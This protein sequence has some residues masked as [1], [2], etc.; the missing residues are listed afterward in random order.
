MLFRV[1]AVELSL[2]LVDLPEDGKRS[3][4]VVEVDPLGL[5]Q[6]HL[7]VGRELL[8]EECAHD[9]ITDRVANDLKTGFLAAQ[10]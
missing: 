1:Q 9:S 2:G 8:G 4:E 10:R 3:S 7:P 5:L 6:V